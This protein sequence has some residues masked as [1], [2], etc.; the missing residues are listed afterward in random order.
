MPEPHPLPPGDLHTYD[1]P[2]ATCSGPWVRIHGRF[3]DPLYFGK[4]CAYRFDDP[5]SLYGVLYAGDQLAGAFIEVF[6]DRRSRFRAI[7]YSELQGVHVSQLEA[8]RP[9]RLVDLRGPGVTF[10]PGADGGLSAMRSYAPTQAWSAALHAHPAF[11][12]GIVYRARRDLEQTSVAIFERAG[13]ALRCTD[14]SFLLEDPGF[15]A[16]LDRYEI[17]VLASSSL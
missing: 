11:P 1:L 6:G 12:D 5:A 8:T 15:E 3:P 17:G 9:L 10:L 13:P 14:T 16:V 4:R 7:A 2:L